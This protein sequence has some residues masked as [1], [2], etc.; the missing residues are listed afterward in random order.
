M[1]AGPL[2]KDKIVE[3]LGRLAE[4]EGETMDNLKRPEGNEIRQHEEEID[5]DHLPTDTSHMAVLQ[6]ED[7]EGDEEEDEE[8]DEEALE[9]TIATAELTSLHCGKDELLLG[10]SLYDVQAE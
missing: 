6:E 7:E 5:M 2:C 3:M 4:A 10:C 1:E 8:G 9:G